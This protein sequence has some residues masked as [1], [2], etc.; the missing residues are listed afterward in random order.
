M[1]NVGVVGDTG[2]AGT[3][4]TCFNR[5]GE[6]A[7]IYGYYNYGEKNDSNYVYYET[8]DEMINDPNIQAVAISNYFCSHT[9]LA[10]KA[11]DAGK[12]VL[13]EVTACV[14][15]KECVE[16]CEAVERNHC[17]YALMESHAFLPTCVEM[18]SQIES[19]VFGPIVYAEGEYCRH[20]RQ[21]GRGRNQE[22][23][24]KA[25]NNGS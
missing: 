17:V 8:F 4:R 7:R 22:C 13:S 11:L 18:K 24:L 15:P 20:L 16:L 19:G 1:I 12:H 25:R 10:I 14:T 3:L 2:R 23:N 5:M 9:E 21:G 6:R